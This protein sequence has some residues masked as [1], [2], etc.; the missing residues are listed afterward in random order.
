MTLEEILTNRNRLSED[1]LH[2]VKESAAGYGVAI[3]RADVKDLVFPGNLQEIMNRVLAAERRSQAH[4][5]DA[6]TRAE[7]A[8]LEA[9]VEA[10]RAKITAEGSA[11]AHRLKAEA[12]ASSERLR[13]EAEIAALGE[14]ADAA[15]AYREHPALMRLR[16]IEALVELAKNANARIYIGLDGRL[17]ADRAEPEG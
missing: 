13:V 7:I 17:K 6:R 8:R 2:D 9:A 11:H 15:D 10:D 1:I 3:L 12:E 5:I 14:R 4:L 16:E